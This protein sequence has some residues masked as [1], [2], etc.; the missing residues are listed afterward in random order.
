MLVH[1]ALQS[2]SK[3][4]STRRD[5]NLPLMMTVSV[6]TPVPTIEKGE[7]TQNTAGNRKEHRI[8]REA[9]KWTY[10]NNR[11]IYPFHRFLHLFSR[12]ERRL[13]LVGALTS[14]KLY[15]VFFKV[16]DQG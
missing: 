1:K 16:S 12:K 13:L 2:S 15:D 5:F 14:L 10:G 3:W 7:T 8:S 4:G 6:Q 11:R 9:A